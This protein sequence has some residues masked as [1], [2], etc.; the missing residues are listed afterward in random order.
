MIKPMLLHEIQSEDLYK[1]VNLGWKAQ[2]KWDGVRGLIDTRSGEPQIFNRNNVNITERLP[3]LVA[4][5]RKLPRCLIDGEIVVIQGNI[6]KGNLANKRCATQKREKILPMLNTLPVS[7]VIFELLALGTK[8]ISHWT[9]EDR[10]DILDDLYDDFLQ[11]SNTFMRIQIWNDIEACWDKAVREKWE[12]IVIKRIG[13]IYLD[14][15]RTYDW[16]KVKVSYTS[17]AF[18]VGYT[19]ST[20]RQFGALVLEDDNGH[21]V[22]NCGQGFTAVQLEEMSEILNSKKLNTITKRFGTNHAV[23]LYSKFKIKFKHYGLGA[24]K[25][26]KNLVYLSQI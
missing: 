11:D 25:H 16:Y 12:G 20:K 14:N 23:M 26:Y 19:E 2:K 9:W 4:E 5:A 17:E 7:F 13:S 21:W 8:D 1:Y 15:S 6:E 3:D 22:G 24:N 18:V 10:Q